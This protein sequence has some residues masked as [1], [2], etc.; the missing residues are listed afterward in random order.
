MANTIG[1]F[2]G[3]A[4][5]KSTQ[6][7]KVAV[8][9]G[10]DIVVHSENGKKFMEDSLRRYDKKDDR[11]KDV[12][13]YTIKEIVERHKRDGIAKKPFVVDELKACLNSVFDGFED[14]VGFSENGTVTDLNKGKRIVVPYYVAEDIRNLKIGQSPH[15][16]LPV[17]GSYATKLWLH[18]T[19]ANSTMLAKGFDIVESMKT[20]L[21]F[22]EGVIYQLTY[23]EKDWQGEWVS[24]V[25]LIRNPTIH[26]SEQF[27]EYTIEGN[28]L[29][30]LENCEEVVHRVIFHESVVSN[31]KISIELPSENWKNVYD[32]FF[33]DVVFQV[34]DVVKYKEDGR[35][36]LVTEMNRSIFQADYDTTGIGTRPYVYMKNI[37]TALSPKYKK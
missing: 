4:S 9:N 24:K 11:V 14:M 34:G 21:K 16:R 18:R 36:E 10:Y 13:V 19:M 30:L 17:E 5:G 32:S 22:A 26:Y 1:I 2:G 7:I 25:L 8:E 35:A 6:V 27:M 3:R 23:S 29:K 37:G 28:F 12:E 33:P 20:P 31:N 15:M